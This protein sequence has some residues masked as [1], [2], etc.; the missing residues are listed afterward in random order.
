MT[1][2]YMVSVLKREDDLRRVYNGCDIDEAVETITKWRDDGYTVRV[3]VLSDHGHRM[4]Y[5]RVPGELGTRRRWIHASRD[6]T[7]I[8]GDRFRGV[9]GKNYKVVDA[10][11]NRLQDAILEREDGERVVAYNLRWNADG[12]LDWEEDLNG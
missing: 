10:V 5:D 9:D 12:T 8:V 7:I 11:E 1:E 4:S 6:G 3:T 2:Y